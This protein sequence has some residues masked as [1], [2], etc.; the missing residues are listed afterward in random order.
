MGDKHKKMV[1]R[2]AR[3][4][5]ENFAKSLARMPRLGFEPG[6]IVSVNGREF[7][8]RRVRGRFVEFTDGSKMRIIP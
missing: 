1:R 6:N 7:E 5:A 8:V 3:Q 2:A 4:A